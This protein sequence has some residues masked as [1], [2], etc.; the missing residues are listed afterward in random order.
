VTGPPPERGHFRSTYLRCVYGIPIALFGLLGLAAAST[1]SGGIAFA[2]PFALLCWFLAARAF[3][4]GVSYS[5]NEVVVRSYLRTHRWPWSDIASFQV[6][7]SAVGAMAYRRKVLEVVLTTGQMLSFNQQN[8]SS[9]DRASPTWIE[10]AVVDL[11][12]ELIE[13]T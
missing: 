9:R 6:S 13:R 4:M 3:R 11:N 7:E 1:G 12:R 5:S 8:A 2:V 10:I